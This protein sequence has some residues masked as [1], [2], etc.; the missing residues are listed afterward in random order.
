MCSCSVIAP[1][2][3]SELPHRPDADLQVDAD[4]EGDGWIVMAPDCGASTD[5]ID[6]NFA[7]F[8]CG[9]L[10]EL[11]VDDVTVSE[12]CSVDT[13]N[14]EWT[15]T[16]GDVARC[17]VGPSDTSDFRGGGICSIVARNFTLEAG[18]TIELLGDN[19]F[20]IAAAESIMVGGT[21]D[22][23]AHGRDN[24]PGGWFGGNAGSPG[25]AQPLENDARGGAGRGPAGGGGG[26][27]HFGAGGSGGCTSSSSGEVVIGCQAATFNAGAGGGGGAY[28]ATCEEGAGGV[29]GA[30]GG[31]VFF[32]ALELFHLLETGLVTTSGADGQ[33]PSRD[34]PLAGGG[35]GGSGGMIWITTTAAALEGRLVARGG[36][37]GS[38]SG[39]VPG[40][41]AGGV[42]VVN[43]G[44]G[45][46]SEEGTGPG[47]GGGGASG[48]VYL[49]HARR[50]EGPE[51]HVEPRAADCFAVFSVCVDD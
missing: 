33:A 31:F 18:V 26:G 8:G 2:E 44:N 5:F 39:S 34:C 45:E 28:D 35:G 14:C 48:F 3:V 49:H 16:P 47:G 25:D 50:W 30:G 19:G 4:S 22:G 15:C 9:N 11:A 7:H 40:G 6:T 23:S 13:T 1:F 27:G 38:G 12:S 37:G 43:G 32:F 51:L 20:A 42:S 41:E 29:G 36:R 46:C 10:A 17:L 21:I 24:S